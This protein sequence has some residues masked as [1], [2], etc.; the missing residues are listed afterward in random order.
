MKDLITKKA[1]ME[2][3]GLVIIVLL[4]SLGF[5]FVVKFVVMAPPKDIRQ[6]HEQ[7]Q[8]S[9]NLLNSLLQSTATDCNNQQIKSL[10]RDCAMSEEIYCGGN[11]SCEYVN[12]TFTKV[13]SQTLDAWNRKYYL[14]VSD[15]TDKIRANFNN[16]N[17]TFGKPCVGEWDNK[18]Y[19]IQAGAQTVIVELNICN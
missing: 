1:Q 13:L 5:L 16:K 10:I 15:P 3:M 11:Y 14:N 9:A 8:M 18:F 19:P 4:I 2:I 17:M 12:E 6:E 7:S